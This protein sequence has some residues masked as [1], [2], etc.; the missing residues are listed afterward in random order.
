[1]GNE[2]LFVG[3]CRLWVA[4]LSGSPV[5]AVSAPTTANGGRDLGPARGAA[6]SIN[7]EEIQ[8]KEGFDIIEERIITK[9]FGVTCSIGEKTQKNLAL[10]LQV[11]EPA[12]VDGNVDIGSDA[13]FT[14]Y[15]AGL[16]HER[17]DGKYIHCLVWKGRAAPTGNATIPNEDFEDTEI[18]ITALKYAANATYEYGRILIEELAW[19]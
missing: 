3:K 18:A 17:T 14:Y 5:A 13:T 2:S 19:S 8:Y 12:T 9:E 4:A 6:I 1:M 7:I 10:F 11:D 15:T 16:E